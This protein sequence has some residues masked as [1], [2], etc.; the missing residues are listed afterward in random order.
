MPAARVL[1]ISSGLA[2][3]AG[4]AQSVAESGSQRGA[5]SRRHRRRGGSRDFA[6]V[7]TGHAGSGILRKDSV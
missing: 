5:L 1:K 6:A 3:A 2:R 7:T 4:R